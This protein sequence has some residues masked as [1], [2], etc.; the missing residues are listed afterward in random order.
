[1]EP[2][3]A[4]HL[5]FGKSRNIINNNHGLDVSSPRRLRSLRH[6]V[7]ASIVYYVFFNYSLTLFFLHV[8]YVKIPLVVK[9]KIKTEVKLR[10]PLEL[11]FFWL[12]SLSTKSKDA[13]FNCAQ[14]YICCFFAFL[15]VLFINYKYI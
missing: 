15:F 6:V 7:V 14:I 9:Y 12:L 11:L 10:K 3:F 4:S 8:I 1:M 13:W 5:S 2:C